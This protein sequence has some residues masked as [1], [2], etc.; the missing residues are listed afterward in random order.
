MVD[1]R[2]P[3]YE[4]PR[5]LRHVDLVLPVLALATAAIGVLMVYSATRGPAT[6]LRP[7]ETFFL[8][9]QARLVGV[10]AG[11]MVLAAW[12]GHRRLQRMLWLIHGVMLGV[13]VAVLAV[14]N[15]VKGSRS[16]F[17][18]GSTQ[19]QP[20]ELGKVALIVVLAAWLGR[21]EAPSG[22]RVLVAV[23]LVAGPVGLIVLQ[24]DLGTVL[25]YGA[26]AAGMVFVAGVK[27]RHLLILGLL[28][29]SGVVAVLQSEVLEDYQ[30]RRLL[31]F[32]DEETDTAASYNLEQ[33]EVAI[34]NGGL[35]GRGLFQGTQNNSALVPEQ[36][37]DFIFTVVAEETGFVG[38]AL[39]LG[40]VGLLLLR[41]LRIGQMADDRFGMLLSAGVFS[42][43]AFQVFQSV[44]MSTGIMPITGIPF[45]LVS[46]GGSSMLTTCLALGLV[47]SV[48]MRRHQVLSRRTESARRGQPA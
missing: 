42:M 17:Q 6:D 39:L 31:V 41:V 4:T 25:V 2:R 44:G 38:G 13:L 46:Y 7:A 1:L 21:T 36:Q 33:A 45:P 11:A 30:I 5:V 23:L 14:G 37:T 47:Q 19:L 3:D 12:F 16:W 26:I 8:G 20:S 9:R 27:G 24:P 15:E 32:V 34:G 22:P 48:H 35:T 43:L 29:V 40:L 18:I 28:L 10:G